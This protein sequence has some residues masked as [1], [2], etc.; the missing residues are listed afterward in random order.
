MQ[1]DV[2]H[3]DEDGLLA[4]RPAKFSLVS[5][6]QVRREMNL[7]KSNRHRWFA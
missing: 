5:K 3:N 2:N 4:L 7:T 1:L 6:K